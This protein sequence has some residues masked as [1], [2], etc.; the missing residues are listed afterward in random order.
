MTEARR[1]KE[2]AST[3]HAREKERLQL[4]IKEAEKQI[5]KME[6]E[7]RDRGKEVEEAKRK[8]TTMTE[9]MKVTEGTIKEKEAS[10]VQLRVEIEGLEEEKSKLDEE[11]RRLTSAHSALEVEKSKLKADLEKMTESCR[12]LEETVEKNRQEMEILGAA[13]EE[14]RGKTAAL[15]S[16]AKT[17][18]GR[19][20]ELEDRVQQL[21]IDEKKYQAEILFRHEQQ[22]QREAEYS[23]LSKK[24]KVN[25][26]RLHSVANCSASCTTCSFV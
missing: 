6:A 14:E 11:L 13:L 2:A 23:D 22:Q 3:A 16:E 20:G 24:L 26:R 5:V 7:L 1:D 21:A 12:L 9:E 8:I 10:N 25:A 4:E 17:T 15:E 19:V 18:E